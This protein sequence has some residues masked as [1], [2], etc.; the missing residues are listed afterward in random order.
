MERHYLSHEMRN[1]PAPTALCGQ[2]L[3]PEQLDC[4]AGPDAGSCFPRRVSCPACRAGLEELLPRR[5]WPQWV[6]IHPQPSGPQN[7]LYTAFYP[8]RQ[9]LRLDKNT[10]VC[11]PHLN[12]P[13]QLWSQPGFDP[14]IP[15]RAY[16]ALQEL[17]QLLAAFPAH[18]AQLLNLPRNPLAELQ[19]RLQRLLAQDHP[20]EIRESL[21]AAQAALPPAHFS[22][23]Y[24]QEALA[25]QPARRTAAAALSSAQRSQ[26]RRLP[27]E[28]R[29]LPP[30]TPE[31]PA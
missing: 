5:H 28:L 11:L 1:S 7:S 30:R 29:C 15:Y 10:E 20:P 25:W 4:S 14:E 17:R 19:E 2:Q 26:A 16:Q 18:P 3:S 12:S 13:A 24:F 31:L 9:E 6:E 21:Q 23:N 27:P 22:P 8:D